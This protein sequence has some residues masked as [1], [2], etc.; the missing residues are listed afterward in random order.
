[1]DKFEILVSG[2][3]GQGVLFLGALLD[4]AARLNGFKS[5]IGS[6]IHGM[7]QRG[8]P[9][10]SYT[11]IGNDVH[12]PII[13]V[14][15]ADVIIGLE[16]IEG[17]R[18][19]ERLSENGTMVVAETKLPSAVM[20]LSGINY[21]DRDEVLA[22]MKKVTDKVTLFDAQSAAKD[23]GNINTA[24]VILLGV[25][26]AAAEDFPINADSMKEAIKVVLP[27]KLVDINLKAFDRGLQA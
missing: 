19:I 12:G 17:L 26:M 11:R 14:G 2:V 16:L 24:N 15:S 18:N 25:T 7:A 4:R 20:W 10:V 3:G 22:S 27:P 9:L 1:M 23:V 6:E 21:P 13:S 8:G 5:V